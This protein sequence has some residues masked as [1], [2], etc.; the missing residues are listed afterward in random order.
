MMKR[1]NEWMNTHTV[2]SSWASEDYDNT[3]VY[4][5]I[6][7]DILCVERNA[8]GTIIDVWEA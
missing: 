4:E 2:D 5:A 3:T 6:N 7:G 8:Q 1:Y